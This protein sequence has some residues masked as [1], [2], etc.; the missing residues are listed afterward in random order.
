MLS[1]SCRG[2]SVICSEQLHLPRLPRAALGV[3]E[4]VSVLVVALVAVV[5]VQDEKAEKETVHY[6]N[7]LRSGEGVDP[8][9]PQLGI[10][11]GVSCHQ[12]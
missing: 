11:T 7:I 8:L 10:L 5:A 9:R 3:S 1:Y 2:I 12:G 4:A 6:Y